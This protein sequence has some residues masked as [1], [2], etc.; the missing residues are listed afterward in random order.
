MPLQ[1]PEN[2]LKNARFYPIL[3]MQMRELLQDSYSVRQVLIIKPHL[4]M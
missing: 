2:K 4:K 1:N 3:H